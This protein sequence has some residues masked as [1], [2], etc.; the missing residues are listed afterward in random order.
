ME[1]SI[2][3]MRFQIAIIVVLHG[4]LFVHAGGE[5]RRTFSVTVD[6]KPAGS[7]ELVIQV[8]DDGAEVVTSQADVTVKAF[9][10]TYKYT[11][12]GVETWKD[13]RLLRLATTTNDDGK[14]HAVVAEA[15]HDGLAVK[16]DGKEM[17]VMGPVWPTSY[18]KLPSEKNRGPGILL[19][20]ADTGK[21]INARIEKVGVEKRTVIDQT[22]EL[23]HYRLTDG[24]KADLWYDNADRLTHQESIE[25]GHL[26]V[27]ELTRLQRN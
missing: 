9:L 25:D 15:I 17:S 21:L 20:D 3:D 11:Y 4:A 6:K 22:V 14:R 13:N 24:V 18:W 1:G 27:L 5:E 12:H 26:T 16:A 8:R 7:N 10:F 23:N 2:V 19:I